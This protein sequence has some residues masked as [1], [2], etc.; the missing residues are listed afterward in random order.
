MSVV[1]SAECQGDFIDM[2]NSNASAV[3]DALGYSEPYGEEDAE[4][5]LGRVLLALAVA[6][7]DAGLPA[8]G[9]DTRFI[10]CG[11]PAGYVQMRLEELHALAQYAATAGLLITWG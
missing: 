8:T 10:D 5:F 2:N 6:P 4:F 7:A 1:F 3:L 9:T 11:R